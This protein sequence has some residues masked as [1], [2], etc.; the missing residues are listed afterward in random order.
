M[1]LRFSFIAFLVGGRQ[2]LRY[3][4]QTNLMGWMS[5]SQK[6]DRQRGSRASIAINCDLSA[7]EPHGKAEKRKFLLV[8]NPPSSPLMDRCFRKYALL[9]GLFP[10]GQHSLSKRSKSDSTNTLPA[11]DTKI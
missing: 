10:S 11:M 1:Q 2:A 6:L 8:F 9:G 3:R 5:D 4:M 7:R